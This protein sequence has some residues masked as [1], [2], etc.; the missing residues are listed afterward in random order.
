[1]RKFI[2]A[3]FTVLLVSTA[4]ATTIESEEVRVDLA[5]GQVDVTLEVEQLTSEK[6]SYITN[7]PVS[8]VSASMNGS[9]IDCQVSP[10]QLGSEIRC[11]PPD[12]TNFTVKLGFQASQ[13]VQR[14]KQTSI[15]RYTHTFYRPTGNYR[16]RVVLPKGA[17][18]L[19]RSNVSTPV[20]S[21]QGAETGSN[22]RRIYVE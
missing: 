3:V 5:T 20:I 7:Y 21:P 15:F 4:A 17:G 13:L 10:L 14:R 22:G 16:L 12:R 19:D 11:E 6:L 18:L 2:A 9:S 8:D 1:M